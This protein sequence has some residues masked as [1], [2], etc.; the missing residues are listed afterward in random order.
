M[1][2]QTTANG[3]QIAHALISDRETAETD[4]PLEKGVESVGAAVSGVEK[5]TL[6]LSLDALLTASREPGSAVHDIRSMPEEIREVEDIRGQVKLDR[7]PSVWH[8]QGDLCALLALRGG[9]TA[10]GQE[11]AR[12][13]S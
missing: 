12:N 5:N 9:G 10:A 11:D 7:G 4:G 2:E 6:L 13:S 1:C 8:M 3:Q